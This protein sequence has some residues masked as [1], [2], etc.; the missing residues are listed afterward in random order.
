MN[1]LLGYVELDYD[2]AIKQN[3]K[4]K[5]DV[6][7][8]WR[9]LGLVEG[10]KPNSVTEKRLCESYERMTAYLINEHKEENGGF[11]TVV[12]P[13]IRR[14]L[15]SNGTGGHISRVVMPKEIIK[16]LETCT[17]QEM[18]DTIKN[19]IPKAKYE[20]NVKLIFRFLS[21]K[22]LADKCLFTIFRLD[23]GL[24]T[25]EERDLLAA[26]AGRS[27]I[28]LEAEVVYYISTFLIQKLK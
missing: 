28:D 27:F 16:V 5:K 18:H 14:I 24:S 8:R 2:E 20:N 17:T 26:L 1:D 3:P 7:N 12:F 22:G 6:V 23:N 11:E 21:Y 25:K 13:I 4:Y 15:T 19:L 9:K 10:I